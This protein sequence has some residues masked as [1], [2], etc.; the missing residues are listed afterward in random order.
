MAQEKAPKL[1]TSSTTDVPASH[2]SLFVSTNPERDKLTCA[3]GAGGCD[4]WFVLLLLGRRDGPL[5]RNEG[6][7][8]V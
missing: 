5:P 1:S 3:G 6:D 7:I 4:F 2:G 8:L